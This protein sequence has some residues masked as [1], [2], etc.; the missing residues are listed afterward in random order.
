MD[1]A[2]G[3]GSFLVQAYRYLLDWYLENYLEDA[4]R[5]RKSKPPRIEVNRSQQYVL[6][7]AERKRILV[8]HIFGVDIDEQAVEVSKLSLLLA[9]LEQESA[10]AVSEQLI[11]FKDR[12]LPDMD[13]NIV[14]GNSL[15]DPAF[16]TDDEIVD[17]YDP[18]R[19]DV[20]AF[21][22]RVFG[23]PFNVVV[24]NPPW[25]MA[26]YEIEPAALD[27]LKTTYASYTG[28]ADLYYLFLEKSLRILAPRGRV[29]MV[30]PSKMFT[31]RAARGLR[32]LLLA[33]SW[34]EE[35]VDFGTE[36]LFE[37][38]TNYT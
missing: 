7:R 26:G 35:V 19:T 15:I 18:H 30:V 4:E 8:D 6:T 38:A 37:S 28:K 14:C 5:W 11:M 22:W 29:G 12:I 23:G 9:L 21:D 27:Y 16:L 33:G 3:S 13:G 24:G 1:P 31:T 2:C 25:L 10:F 20:R 36:K 34:P 32:E 17:S